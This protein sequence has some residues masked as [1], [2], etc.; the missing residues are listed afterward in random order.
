[1]QLYDPLSVL[2][3]LEEAA[4]EAEEAPGQ[5]AAVAEERGVFQ[6]WYFIGSRLRP[7]RMKIAGVRN[8]FQSL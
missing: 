4:G 7:N 2:Q 5:Q 3:G 8:E 1:M 6:L